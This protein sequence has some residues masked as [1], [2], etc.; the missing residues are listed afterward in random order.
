LRTHSHNSR[1]KHTAYRIL[2]AE[3]AIIIVLALLLLVAIDGPAAVSAVLGGGAY[4]IPNALFAG[5]AFRYSAVDSALVAIRWLGI[6]EVVKLATTAI[7][8]AACFKYLESINILALFSCY[9]GLLLI[10]VTAMAW[11]GF[12]GGKSGALLKS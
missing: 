9:A 3:T 4:I 2:A 1:A 8:F 5:Y 10:N 6:G 7:I 11:Q 12:G